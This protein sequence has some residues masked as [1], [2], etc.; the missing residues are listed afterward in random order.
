MAPDNP[1]LAIT[2]SSAVTWGGTCP[3]GVSVRTYCARC[4]ARG[5]PAAQVPAFPVQPVAVAGWLCTGC[6]HGYSPLVTEC[7]R[8]P[9]Q[10][11]AAAA[12]ETVIP[13]P[14]DEARAAFERHQRAT[15]PDVAD[16]WPVR[17]PAGTGGVAVTSVGDPPGTHGSGIGITSG[18]R[19]EPAGVEDSPDC[20]GGLC[21]EVEGPCM[22]L[23]CDH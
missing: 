19:C 18:V 14:D 15:V 23:H 11:A 8:C 16:G 21:E 12:E 20:G 9:Q 1:N 22:R 10:K 6:G 2:P 17:M 3:H 5:A 13:N 7:P 4:L